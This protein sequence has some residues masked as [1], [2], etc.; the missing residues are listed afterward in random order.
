MRPCTFLPESSTPAQGASLPVRTVVTE[1]SK[2][3][4]K[5]WLN[6]PPEYRKYWK[7]RSPTSTIGFKAKR[8]L[9]CVPRPTG[10]RR[11]DQKEAPRPGGGRRAA[12][13]GAHKVTIVR[14]L[15][16]AARRRPSSHEYFNRRLLNDSGRAYAPLDAV[17]CDGDDSQVA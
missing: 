1:A 17:P 7:I 3:I 5:R 11:A 16:S 6:V 10:Q 12:A 14:T 9:Y 15:M 13:A 8:N 4:R 2:N